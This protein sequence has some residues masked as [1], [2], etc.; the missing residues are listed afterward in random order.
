VAL[1]ACARRA[2]RQAGDRAAGAN[3]LAGLGI[4]APDADRVRAQLIADIRAGSRDG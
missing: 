2:A 1:H 4:T 3:A